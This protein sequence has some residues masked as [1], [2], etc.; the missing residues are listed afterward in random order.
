MKKFLSVCMVFIMLMTL[1]PLT[2]I[3]DYADGQN[4]ESCGHYHWDSYC[5][6][7]C[8]RCTSDCT[9][10]ECYE[11]TH[12]HS[13]GECFAD[14]SENEYCT[15]CWNCISCGENEH[16]KYCG[17]CGRDLQRLSFLRRLPADERRHLSVL[18]RLSDLSL[19]RGES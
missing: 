12:C 13:C 2:A 7:N 10:S 5:C 4:C 14:M 17:E 16:C 19:R 1:L 8:G 6:G 9:N 3:A 11:T 15:E 18:R